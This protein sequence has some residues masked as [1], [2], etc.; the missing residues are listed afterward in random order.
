MQSAV[1]IYKR[2][3]YPLHPRDVDWRVSQ[4]GTDKNGKPWAIV[5]PY[6]DARAV[7]KRLNQIFGIAGWQS[8]MIR[9]EHDCICELTCRVE[10]EWITKSDASGD[11]NVES[12]KGGASASLRRAAANWGIGEYLYFVP[13]TFANAQTEQPPKGET[14]IFQKGGK[15]GQ[16]FYWQ[17]PS[18]P[19]RCIPDTA[20]PADREEVISLLNKVNYDV[21][22][23]ADWL[24]GEFGVADF[25]DLE[26]FLLDAVMA[27][28]EEY[29]KR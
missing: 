29:G 12:E 18:L 17:I 20:K 24:L 14:W 23:F 4:A 25:M 10:G 21:N 5:V 28:I 3:Q 6:L 11:T 13:T 27:H 9:G 7:R 1:T 16:S 8:K 19:A 15:Q 26:C 22:A 2:C